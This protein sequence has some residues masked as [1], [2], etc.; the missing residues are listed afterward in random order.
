MDKF[1]GDLDT[2]VA[3]KNINGS[4]II[5]VFTITNKP[6]DLRYLKMLH[7]EC[8][9]R[10]VQLVFGEPQEQIEKIKMLGSIL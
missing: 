9:K 8:N 10:G 6:N 7:H 4:N 5:L 2:L 1:R 3:Y